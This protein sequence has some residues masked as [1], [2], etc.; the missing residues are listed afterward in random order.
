[1]PLKSNQSLSQVA[2]NLQAEPEQSLVFERFLLGLR[3]RM[4]DTMANWKRT[5]PRTRD[6]C[7]RCGWV[8]ISTGSQRKRLWRIVTGL[9]LLSYRRLWTRVASQ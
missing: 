6:S 3:L 9:G 1:M 8:I 7:K 2:A 4:A 5:R